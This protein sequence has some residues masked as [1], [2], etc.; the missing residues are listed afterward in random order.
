MHLFFEELEKRF[1]NCPHFMLGFS[2][3]SFLLR[4]YL[5]RY[6]D[7][8]AGALILGTGSQPGAVLSVVMSVVKTQIKKVGFDRTT[9]LVKKYLLKHTIKN[10]H[11]IGL[12]QIGY[13]LIK[14][15]F[16]N[17]LQIHFAD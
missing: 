16:R 4:E 15:N 14:M 13:V 7:Q 8:I 11:R 5:N 1:Q 10:L 9:S 12:R 6:P 3:G 17:I 2:L